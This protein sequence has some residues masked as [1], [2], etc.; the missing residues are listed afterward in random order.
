M[1]GIYYHITTQLVPPKFDISWTRFRH[2]EESF[3]NDIFKLSLYLT[4]P[5]RNLEHLS[6]VRYVK[7]FENQFRKSHSVAGYKDKLDN[8]IVWGEDGMISEVHGIPGSV[9]RSHCLKTRKPK[10]EVSAKINNFKQS[11]EL[12]ICNLNLNFISF[13]KTILFRKKNEKQF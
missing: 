5:K 8:G 11:I 4:R 6:K 13:I 2:K 1:P 9:N 10:S 12:S 7:I 3:G